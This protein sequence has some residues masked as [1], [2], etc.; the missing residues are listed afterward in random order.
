[1]ETTL[2][3]EGVT[4]FAGK[5]SRLREQWPKYY[6]HKIYGTVTR[7]QRTAP[8]SVNGVDLKP[9]A[10]ISLARAYRAGTTAEVHG[11][12]APAK[13]GPP[14]APR[15]RRRERGPTLVRVPRPP[16]KSVGHLQGASAALRICWHLAEEQHLARRWQVTGFNR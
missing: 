9:R 1:M 6:G 7:P 3:S 15:N 14:S 5:L 13:R 10:L 8:A 12:P 16:T 11:P 2:R 4:H